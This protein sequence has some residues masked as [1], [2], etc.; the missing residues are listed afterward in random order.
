MS[1]I[2]TSNNCLFSRVMFTFH[3]GLLASFLSSIE[4][5]RNSFVIQ[6][7]YLKSL[8]LGFGKFHYM[9]CI[10]SGLIYMDSAIGVTIL[11]FVLPAAQCDLQMDSE[12][13]GLL[14]ASPMLGESLTLRFIIF[15]HL[16]SKILTNLE[17]ICT[18]LTRHLFIMPKFRCYWKKDP[19]IIYKHS[20]IHLENQNK[21]ITQINTSKYIMQK[22]Q[23][24][25]VLNFLEW[26]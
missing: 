17:Q 5:E 2:G 23:T 7:L 26:R 6:K 14:S 20:S 24:C 11:S 4:K 9:I 15:N 19:A 10:I 21:Y 3:Y 13:K 25:V 1:S 18:F 12:A 22:S 16:Y 8:F